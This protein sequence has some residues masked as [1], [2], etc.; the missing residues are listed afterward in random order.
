VDRAAR[1]DD[2]ALV[3]VGAEASTV[4]L[5]VGVDALAHRE[6]DIVVGPYS[7]WV[8]E[9]PSGRVQ[10]SQDGWCVVEIP[11]GLRVAAVDGVTP[12]VKSPAIDGVDG[13]RIAT[14]AIVNALVNSDKRAGALLAASDGVNERL[15]NAFRESLPAD[16]PRACVAVVEIDDSG[17]VE[18]LLHGDCEVW[19]LRHGT[20]S[21]MLGGSCIDPRVQREWS[22]WVNE[23]PDATLE[24]LQEYERRRGV[25]DAWLCPPIGMFDETKPRTGSLAG[26]EWDELIVCSDGLRATPERLERLGPWLAEQRQWERDRLA[27]GGG[28]GVHSYKPHDDRT[29]IRVRRRDLEA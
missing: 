29:L 22:I 12:G 13:A 18:A 24:E 25:P 5:R 10:P 28:Q 19:V 4:D 27:G 1:P 20:W 6:A 23:H 16:R 11:G 21:R 14:R 7:A 3:D 2:L 8:F 9:E 17:R 15:V 26:D